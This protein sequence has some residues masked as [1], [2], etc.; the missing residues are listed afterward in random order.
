MFFTFFTENG[1]WDFMQNCL[2][3]TIS[4]KCRIQSSGKSKT[5]TINLSSAE[6][7]QRMVKIKEWMCPNILDSYH[8]CPKYIRQLCLSKQSKPRLDATESTLLTI[9][10]AHL[11]LKVLVTNAADVFFFFF[12]FLVFFRENKTCHF[13]CQILFSL[14]N[15]KK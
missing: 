10:L 1:G 15:D 6:L 2:K 13:K 4:M 3:S 9:S 7:A 8:V 5:N 12:F 14:K 11:T